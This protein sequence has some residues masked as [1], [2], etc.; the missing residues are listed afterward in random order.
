MRTNSRFFGPLL[1]FLLLLAASPAAGTM[2]D[3]VHVSRQGDTATLEIVAQVLT[4]GAKTNVA[5]VV[6]SNQA[7]PNSM[8]GNDVLSED[9][10][11]AALQESHRRRSS[12][13]QFSHQLY[14]PLC[15]LLSGAF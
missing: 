5:E 15:F 8:P 9:D 2:L 10:Q 1:G 12:P 7:D 13:Y 4:V 14:H 11:D 6:A 3:Y